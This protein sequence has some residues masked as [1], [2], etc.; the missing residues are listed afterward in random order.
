MSFAD[1]IFQWMLK[2]RRP[3]GAV[4]DGQC[5]ARGNLRVVVAA[6]E[7]V[8]ST[9]VDPESGA[10]LTHRRIVAAQAGRR[11]RRILVTNEGPERRWFMLFDLATMPIANAQPVLARPL[12]PSEFYAWEFPRSRVF[13]SGI[14][15]AASAAPSTYAEDAAAAFRVSVELD[16]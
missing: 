8:P 12:Q 10:Q 2:L 14:T 3:D 15:W 4:V 16:A 9:W 6:T 5:D 7:D 13:A 11:L 1:T